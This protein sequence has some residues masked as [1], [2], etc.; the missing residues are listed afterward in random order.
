MIYVLAVIGGCVVVGVLLAL[1]YAVFCA[2][3]MG[4]WDDQ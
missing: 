4:G 2:H 1:S 3:L